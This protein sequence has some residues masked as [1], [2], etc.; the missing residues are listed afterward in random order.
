MGTTISTGKSKFLDIENWPSEER[1]EA[2]VKKYGSTY[3][4]DMWK[5]LHV[6]KNLILT[7]EMAERY[8]IIQ[9]HHMRLRGKYPPDTVKGAFRTR[10]SVKNDAGPGVS[11]EVL[12]K[13]VQG[14]L[15]ARLA[16]MREK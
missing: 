2:M 8:K 7:P 3:T 9:D 10:S 6:Q 4:A 13:A 12:D 5:I 1:I 15:A 16:K 11:D 14:G